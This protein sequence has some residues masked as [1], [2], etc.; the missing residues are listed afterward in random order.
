MKE[1]TTIL[2]GG[3]I[4]DGSATEPFVGDILFQGDR[5]LEV[6]HTQQD[7]FRRH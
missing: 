2:K 3:R 1:T 7:A 4:Y 5:I 6:A